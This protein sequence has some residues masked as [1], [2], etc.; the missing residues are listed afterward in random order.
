MS[1]EPNAPSGWEQTKE[2]LLP[3]LRRLIVTIIV[4]GFALLLWELK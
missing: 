4:I 1:D 3:Y 2:D